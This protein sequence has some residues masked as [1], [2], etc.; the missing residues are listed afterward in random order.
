M[1][2]PNQTGSGGNW[3]FFG[4]GSPEPKFLGSRYN[5]GA[6]AIDILAL[7][8]KAPL[9]ETGPIKSTLIEIG[10]K[11]VRLVKPNVVPEM[12]DDALG[13][14]KKKF[15]CDPG[16]IIVFYGDPDYDPGRIK[17]KTSTGGNGN[18]VVDTFLK[19]FD[20]GVIRFRIGMWRQKKG[21][22][23]EVCEDISAEDGPKI[24]TGISNALWAAKI[25]IRHGSKK[26]QD[27]IDLANRGKE[28]QWLLK[29]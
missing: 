4:A 10:G 26:A 28:Q 29:N 23:N 17:M 7:T 15:V 18:R 21:R 24:L 12:V 6:A 5:V 9:F 20:P 14:I 25:L 1:N 22:F 13:L 2:E 19:T 3:L 8:E 27:F 16:A 11:A